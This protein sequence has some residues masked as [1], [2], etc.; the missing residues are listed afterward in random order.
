MRIRQEGSFALV[1]SL[2]IG[3][4]V[5]AVVLVFGWTVGLPAILL[6][7]SAPIVLCQD[8]LRFV[9]IAEARPHVAA[10]WDG[11]WF[12]GAVLFTASFSAGLRIATV[13]LLIGGWGCLLWSRSSVCR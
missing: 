4:A 7:A 3:V 9:A 8:V 10:V 2:T 12:V 1:A 13:P 5:F 11:I 6:A